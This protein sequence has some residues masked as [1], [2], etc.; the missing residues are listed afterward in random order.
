MPKTIRPIRVEGDVAYVT[1]T[2]GYEAVIDAN[3]VP[4]V[5]GFNW[6]A[7]LRKW[8]VY[9]VRSERGVPKRGAI[10]MHRVILGEPK[11]LDVDHIDGNGLNNRKCNLRKATKSQNMHNQGVRR[12][13]TSGFKGVSWRESRNKWV[14]QICLKGKVKY[15]GMFDTPEDAYSAYCDASQKLHGEFSKLK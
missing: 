13:N 11:D 4:L 8:G 9:A 15:L 12:S 14:A 1:L 5:E 3:D 6:Q 10:L 7:Q 2:R